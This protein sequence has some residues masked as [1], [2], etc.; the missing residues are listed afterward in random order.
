MHVYLELTNLGAQQKIGLF[1]G[2]HSAPQTY[3]SCSEHVN[4]NSLKEKYDIG[5]AEILCDPYMQIV[6]YEFSVIKIY[7][8]GTIERRPSGAARSGLGEL[9]QW[10]DSK[11]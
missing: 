7:L 8:K 3:H 10:S 2:R 4:R 6:F 1:R 11:R 5:E 9:L